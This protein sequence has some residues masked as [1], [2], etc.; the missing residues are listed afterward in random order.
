[1]GAP[2]PSRFRHE[3][4]CSI[5]VLQPR[6][7]QQTGCTRTGP[8]PMNMPSIVASALLV[9]GIAVASAPASAE[10][11]RTIRAAI[12]FSSAD[13]A[14]RIY[15]SIERAAERACTDEGRRPLSLRRAERECVLRLVEA[16]VRTIG[17]ADIAAVH[18]DVL[19]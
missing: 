10:T 12:S 19:A 9:L 17:R 18:D 7:P 8:S 2:S 16:G 5:V 3:G 6:T 15:A 14:E 11:V 1:M 4:G 13:S